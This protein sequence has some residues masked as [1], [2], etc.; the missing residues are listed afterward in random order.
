MPLYGCTNDNLMLG[1]LYRLFEPFLAYLEQCDL[2]L[3]VHHRY[4]PFA[5]CERQPKM[6]YFCWTLK[7]LI[8]VHVIKRILFF[9]VRK[10]LPKRGF[11]I[12]GH[13]PIRAQSIN[14]KTILRVSE[15]FPKTNKNCTR[16]GYDSLMTVDFSRQGS[17]RARV[18][19][20]AT[21]A[22]FALWAP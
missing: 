2:Y 15:H 4:F 7:L 12:G 13:W 11:Q 16:G 22:K 5:C 19:I 8:W 21:S 9:H 6:I 1:P 14:L 18:A 3:S 10:L 17:I 20:F